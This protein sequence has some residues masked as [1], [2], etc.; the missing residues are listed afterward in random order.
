MDLF[1]FQSVVGKHVL[2]VDG[3]RI[4]DVDELG[5]EELNADPDGAAARFGLTSAR[6]YVDT[7]PPE[8]PSLHALSLNVA[9]SCN[10]AC[11]YCY[12]DE[13]RFGSS[14]RLMPEDTAYRA[15]DLLLD[16][17][18]DT[19]SAV[20]GFM[21]GEPLVNRSLVRNATE[22]AAREA[23]R[24][25]IRLGFSIT[26]NATL[27]TEADA[28]FLDAHA[29]TV[30]VS[31]DGPKYVNDLQR[32]DRTGASSYERTRA[33]L[34]RL[35]AR[36]NLHVSVR[37]TVTPGGGRLLPILEDLLSLGADEVGF[38]P[39]LVSPN[40]RMAFKDED[41]IDLLSAMIE[42]GEAAKGAL[43]QRRS[44][45]FSNFETGLLEIARGAHRPYSCGAAAGYGSVAADGKLSAC[46]RAIGDPAFAIG[47]L[48]NGTDDAARTKFLRE[49]HVLQQQPC[50]GCWARFLCGGG[51]HHE[52]HAR[53]RPGCDY[54]RGWLSYLLSAYVE[55]GEK[56]PSYFADPDTFFLSS[57]AR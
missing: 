54:I 45:P 17:A 6:Q 56:Q 29:F 3:S 36:R 35:L 22:R 57:E 12:A 47:D 43:L 20:L 30:A 4:Y 15:I 8:L 18:E 28:D 10:L 37:A 51:C 39:V 16:E 49:H 46:H 55:I 14:A 38:A 25:G 9:Q 23:E 44:F 42:C 13:G 33:G 53:G 48:D 50:S 52:V 32:P 2:V 24:R 21:G 19:G 11:G 26:T 5:F 34:A 41:F 7:T 31:L 27:L 1:P 40:P